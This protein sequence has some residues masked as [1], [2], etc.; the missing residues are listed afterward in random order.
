MDIIGIFFFISI[1]GG[2][3]LVLADH[4]YLWM[5]RP[6]EL[7]RIKIQRVGAVVG[8]RYHPEYIRQCHHRSDYQ[9]YSIESYAQHKY[10]RKTYE[11]ELLLDE[12]IRE[13]F[14]NESLYQFCKVGDILIIDIEI[15]SYKK[16][17]FFHQLVSKESCLKS[18]TGFTFSNELA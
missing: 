1:L 3:L 15:I 9:P 7:S 14:D 16:K 8:K 12:D 5:K 2:L 17:S 11:V 18:W 13:S 6:E 10:Q 4:I